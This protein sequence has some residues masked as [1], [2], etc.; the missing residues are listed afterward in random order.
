MAYGKSDRTAGGFM[1]MG[2]RFF[3]LQNSGLFNG[4]A[5][6]L[7]TTQTKPFLPRTAV[8]K[9]FCPST[10]ISA[11]RE[12]DGG[13]AV[14]ASAISASRSIR[15]CSIGAMLAYSDLVSSVFAFCAWMGHAAPNA[16]IN[17]VFP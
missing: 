3:G 2:L 12:I 6:A 9:F 16:A 1:Q 17:T 4:P 13:A 8:S 14:R 7:P 10:R 5:N 15:Y 11:S